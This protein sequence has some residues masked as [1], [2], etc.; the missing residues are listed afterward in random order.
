MNPVRIDGAHLSL[1]ELTPSD[2]PAV[3]T[4]Y[5]DPEA[6]RHLSFEPRTAEEVDGVVSRSIASA[7]ADPRTEYALA[8]VR[9]TDGD[10]IGMARLATEPQQAA[11][12]GFAL[13][14]DTWGKG[15]GTELVH[16]L[17]ALGFTH[18]G[19]HR[20]WAARAPLNTAS[21]RTLRKA[22]MTEDGRIRDH[23]YV[24][25]AWRDSIVYSI[26]EHEWQPPADLRPQAH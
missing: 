15:L 13:H 21:D 19:L 10:L 1:R 16:V 8:V 3:L 5:G 7:H 22:G 25:G 24:R 4:I 6:T 26:L 2:S 20:I 11:T 9:R 14:R 12:I 17:C 18:L 23:V